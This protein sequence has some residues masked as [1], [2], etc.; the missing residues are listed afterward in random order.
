MTKRLPRLPSLG[1]LRPLAPAFLERLLSLQLGLRGKASPGSQGS[2]G[3]G[4]LGG[5]TAGALGSASEYAA[6]PGRAP[7]APAR[8]A[9]VPGGRHWRRGLGCRRGG[10]GPARGGASGR[11][12]A[13]PGEAGGRAVSDPPWK[14]QWS[15]RCRCLALLNAKVVPRW[16]L[17]GAVQVGGQ[18]FL[19][20]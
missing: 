3:S 9:Y 16:G 2:G 12:V 10:P 8:A 19:I 7:R 1:W 20:C 13:A 5:W 14:V 6:G 18:L 17:R 15:R 4:R 11:A